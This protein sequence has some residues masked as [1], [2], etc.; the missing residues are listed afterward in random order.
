MTCNERA[1][2]VQ[3][4]W[5]PEHP[6]GSSGQPCKSS[7]IVNYNDEYYHHWLKMRIPSDKIPCPISRL[8]RSKTKVSAQVLQSS[9]G[10]FPH[11][12]V[13]TPHR[14]RGQALSEVV[15]LSFE[16]PASGSTFG[17]TDFIGLGASWASVLWAFL[18]V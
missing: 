2:G 11:I 10:P 6:S 1:I 13:R 3:V 8:I 18:F 15:V 14:K 12:S 7:L 16:I 4:S 17:H 5:V 9:V